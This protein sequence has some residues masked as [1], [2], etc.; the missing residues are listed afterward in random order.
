MN[1]RGEYTSPSR[2]ARTVCFPSIVRNICQKAN[3]GCH[4]F[5]SITDNPVAYLPSPDCVQIYL[6][7]ADRMQYEPKYINTTKIPIHTNN[8]VL[9]AFMI[10]V[11]F[12]DKSLLLLSIFL[13]HYSRYT[14]VLCGRESGF[15]RERGWHAQGKFLLSRWRRQN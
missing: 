3:F 12:I 5:K 14:K 13:T 7:V 4:C 9:F 6:P 8:L 1:I 10:P 11:A 15:C 2:F